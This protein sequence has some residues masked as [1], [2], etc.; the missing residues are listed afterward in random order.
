MVTER[1]QLGSDYG[2]LHASDRV[3][4]RPISPLP[5]SSPMLERTASP[6]LSVAALLAAALTLSGCDLVGDVLE[7]GF[8]A[9]VIVVA[10]IAL[11]I[12][13]AVRAFSRKT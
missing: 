9:G 13:F 8:W 6:R 12:W 3:A 1:A 7:F 11:G 5:L 4:G 10:L 2:T